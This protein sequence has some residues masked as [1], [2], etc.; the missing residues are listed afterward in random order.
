MDLYFKQLAPLSHLEGKVL[1]NYNYSA[2]QVQSHALAYW[3]GGNVT[4]IEVVQYQV[5]FS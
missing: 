3:L 1:N 4:P 5:V 2:G